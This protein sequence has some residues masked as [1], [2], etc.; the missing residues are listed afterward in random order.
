MYNGIGLPTTRGSGTNGFVQRNLAFVSKKR[1]MRP[2]IVTNPEKDSDRRPNLE[3]ILHQKKREIEGKCIRLRK[4]L[5]DEGWSNR[6]I[7]EEVHAYRA[8]KLDELSK[9]S[10]DDHDK[11]LRRCF[12][13]D[14]HKKPEPKRESKKQ[15]KREVKIE[16][17]VI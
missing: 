1:Q 15:P 13:I 7:E 9:V 6:R 3:L 16:K 8:R 14:E 12:R 11:R 2:K 4:E 5:E 10:P 17:D